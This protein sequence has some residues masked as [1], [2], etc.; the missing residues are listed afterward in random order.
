L[1]KDIPQCGKKFLCDIVEDSRH[2]FERYLNV[3]KRAARI[4]AIVI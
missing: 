1:N 2:V 3:L 4:F